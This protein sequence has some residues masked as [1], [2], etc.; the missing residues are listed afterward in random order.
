MNPPE[1]GRAE[2]MAASLDPL[3]GQELVNKLVG[4]IGGKDRQQLGRTGNGQRRWHL[5]N[6]TEKT[7]PVAA[8]LN[9]YSFTPLVIV[10]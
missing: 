1:L 3:T 10:K 8:G 7:I 2:V 5:M 4:D 9:N 6:L